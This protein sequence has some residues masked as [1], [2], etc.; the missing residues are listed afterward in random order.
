LSAGATDGFVGISED[1]AH[2]LREDRLT[3]LSQRDWL[4]GLLH[5]SGF[6]NCLRLQMTREWRDARAGSTRCIEWSPN[7]ASDA[8]RCD[9]N[10]GQDCA[11]I[12]LAIYGSVG[13]A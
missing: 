8:C 5:R 11:A 9:R 3:R 4:T 13:V 10:S 7:A 6:E 1:T 12:D 2:K